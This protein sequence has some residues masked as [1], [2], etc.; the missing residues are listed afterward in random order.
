MNI[1]FKKWSY[2]M[3]MFEVQKLFSSS[4]FVIAVKEDFGTLLPEKL[5][6]IFGVEGKSPMSNLSRQIAKY[7]SDSAEEID[8]KELLSDYGYETIEDALED[9]N[10]VA[11]LLK[12]GNR[13]YRFSASY[14]ESN[15]PIEL[16]IGNGGLDNIETENFKLIQY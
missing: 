9:G 7:I 16:M 2:K 5:F 6:D 12:D 11:Q 4:S 15:D 14:N 3:K 8:L 13:V 1:N 10:V